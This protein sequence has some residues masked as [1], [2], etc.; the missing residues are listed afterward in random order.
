MI[1]ERGIPQVNKKHTLICQFHQVLALARDNINCDK[2][3]LIHVADIIRVGLENHNSRFQIAKKLESAS[4][5]KLLMLGDN[6]EK[7]SKI[8]VAAAF[9]VEHG[10]RMEL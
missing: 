7:L 1:T 10:H 2:N 9:C 3:T 5:Q 6:I 4:K 8:Y